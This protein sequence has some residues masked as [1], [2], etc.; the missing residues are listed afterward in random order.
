MPYIYSLAGK[1][2]FEDYTIMR[3]LIMDFNGDAEVNSIADQ[4][5]FGP[6]LMVAPVYKYKAT[7]REVYFPEA[8]GW[9]DLY[10]G[11]YINGGQKI[12]V[13]APYERMPLFVK[14][15]SIVPFGPEI[16]YTG[17]KQADAITLYVY[18]GKDAEF[19]L[20]ED[21]GVNYNYEKGNFSTIQFNYSEESGKLTIGD[22]NG[23][24]EGMLKTRTF[25]I[26]WI[27]K[28]KPVAFDLSKKPDVTISYE[29]KA[30]DV[31]R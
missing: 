30:I 5:M 9:Y 12:S 31:S 6:S 26:V 25:N 2:H 1:T 20:Y 24:F 29:G 10:S 4:Y 14:E 18:T 17:E 27:G 23:Q 21:E 22:A 28:Q 15:G 19:K 8:N 13:D 11:K 7:T 3:A 16:Q